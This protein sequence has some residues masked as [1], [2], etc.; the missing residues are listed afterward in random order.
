MPAMTAALFLADF[1]GVSNGTFLHWMLAIS[2]TLLVLDVFFNTEFLSW[3]SMLVF[4]LWGTMQFE[5]PVQWSVLVYISI[6]VVSA[7]FYYTLWTHCVRRLVMDW[8]LR[9]A[10]REAQECLAGTRARVVGEGDSLSIKY[11]DQFLP[12]AE[13]CRAG[14]SAGDAV[15]IT[16]VKDGFARVER[17]EL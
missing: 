14:L 12:V 8:I 1:F 3:V 16:E 15:T 7:V 10:P 2:L 17:A 4:S 13:D 5:L 6:L 11:G 9:R